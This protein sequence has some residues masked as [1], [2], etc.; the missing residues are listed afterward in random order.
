MTAPEPQNDGGVPL[1]GCLAMM[2]YAFMLLGILGPWLQAHA[3]F[4]A[5]L[6]KTSVRV[7]CGDGGPE[8]WP[9]REMPDGSVACYIQDKPR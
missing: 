6:T 9:A 1:L 8:T 2:A 4:K 5:A 7:Q 3:L